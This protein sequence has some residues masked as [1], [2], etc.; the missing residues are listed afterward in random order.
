MWCICCMNQ[1]VGNYVSVY[2]YIHDMTCLLWRFK[3]QC[4][5]QIISACMVMTIASWEGFSPAFQVLLRFCHSSI[6]RSLEKCCISNI[7]PVR[8]GSCGW[9]VFGWKSLAKLP[10]MLHQVS[11]FPKLEVP[12][13]KRKQRNST[14]RGHLLV[15]NGVTTPIN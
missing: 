14:K 15:S 2:I 4:I 9:R 6:P 10:Y 7:A 5:H 3:Y 13:Q 11:V 8:I 12:L 1:T